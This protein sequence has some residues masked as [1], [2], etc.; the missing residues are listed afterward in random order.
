M[1]VLI[2]P[3]I[4]CPGT[5]GAEAMPS[6]GQELSETQQNIPPTVYLGK[7]VVMDT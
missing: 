6:L 7:T 4:S 1:K 5:D 3:G 2:P